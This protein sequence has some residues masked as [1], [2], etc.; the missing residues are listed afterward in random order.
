MNK[1]LTILFACL[2]LLSLS[3]CKFLFKK[4]VLEKIHDV[5]VLSLDPDK[6]E[7]ELT[8]S[9]HNPN[10]YKLKLNSLD[11]TLLSP[12]REKIGSAFLKDE[13]LIPKKRSNALT[14]RISL[15]TRST[16]KTINNS[17]QKVFVYIAGSGRG[18]VLGASKK[19][20]FEEPFE[21]DVREQI[22]RV[23]A[24]FKADGNDIFKVKRSYVSKLGLT[25][26][27]IRVDFII[28]NP[29]GLKFNFNGFPATITIGDKESGSGNL[30]QELSFDEKIYSQE[31]TMVFKINNWKA[32][33]NAVKGVLNGEIRYEVTGR[34]QIDAYGIQIERPYSYS[35]MIAINISELV[36]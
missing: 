36:F 20:E 4:P 21:I 30:L 22:Q 28:L 27:Q 35:D 14:F 19:F 23:V 33:V 6:T 8:L 1:M 18:K 32:I 24:G 17:D 34:V 9:V 10:A 7:L 13:V 11:I 16:V 26:S 25:E 2:A 5:K 12:K 31:G 15:D 29:Y 3:G